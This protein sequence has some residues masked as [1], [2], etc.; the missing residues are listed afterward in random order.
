MCSQ[1]PQVVEVTVVL[2]VA[3]K[4]LQRQR[5]FEELPVAVIWE[6]IVHEESWV[7]Q[8]VKLVVS[9]RRRKR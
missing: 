9:G 3:L 5:W 8:K 1:Q 7:S 6:V 4:L 2:Q